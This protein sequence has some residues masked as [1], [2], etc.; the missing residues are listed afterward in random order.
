LLRYLAP[1]Q[2]VRA[3]LAALP[4]PEV[5]FVYLGRFDQ[6]SQKSPVFGSARGPAGAEQSPR[7]R[8]SHLL[9]IAA[10][11]SG[12]CL[13]V[14][15]TYGGN[16]IRREDV[17]ELTESF[18]GF[19][20]NFIASPGERSD[21]GYAVEDFPQAALSQGDLEEILAQYEQEDLL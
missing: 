7:G 2:D 15:I 17:E 19:L 14:N 4:S 18:A 5:L 16:A 11:V 6:L 1:E 13:T 21:I 3:A 20:L 9:E 10:L 8:R 12:D